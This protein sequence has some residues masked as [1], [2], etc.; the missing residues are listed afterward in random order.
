MNNLS[1][2]EVKAEAKKIGYIFLLGCNGMYKICD[3]NC[4]TIIDINTLDRCMWYLKNPNILKLI[5]NG[6]SRANM[7]LKK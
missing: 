7:E 3:N 6:N 5:K 1:F 2:E 4:N